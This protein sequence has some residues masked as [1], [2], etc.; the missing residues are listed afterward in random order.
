MITPLSHQQ[1]N[2]AL[3]ESGLEEKEWIEAGKRR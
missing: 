3:A 2:N 1:V